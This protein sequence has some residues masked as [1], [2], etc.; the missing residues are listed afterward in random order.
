[1]RCGVGR[2]EARVAILQ[3][4]LAGQG[5]SR[6]AR[7]ARAVLAS[8]KA[9]NMAAWVTSVRRPV[10]RLLRTLERRRPDVVVPLLPFEAESPGTPG[11]A[12]SLLEWL[13][14][15]YVGSRPTI[16]GVAED[17]FLRCAALEAAGLGRGDLGSPIEVGIVSIDESRRVLGDVDPGA[18]SAAIAAFEA[19]GLRD[20][21]TIRVQPDAS[22]GWGVAGV[23]PILG[24]ADPDVWVELVRQARERA[25]SPAD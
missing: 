6:D 24:I 25:T 3:G 1:M 15:P 16:L 20:H 19:L 12:A 7:L 23:S 5:T 21:A 2:H 17:D 11:L 8:L 9:A 18:S 4:G 14:L 10:G 13:E 22:H